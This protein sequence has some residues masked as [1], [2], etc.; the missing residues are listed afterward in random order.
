MSAMKMYTLGCRHCSLLTLFVVVTVVFCPPYFAI[1]D[2]S[3]VLNPVS[4][5]ILHH[6]SRWVHSRSKETS[7]TRLKGVNR[8]SSDVFISRG[9]Q[10]VVHIAVHKPKPE[11]TVCGLVSEHAGISIERA[12]SLASLGSIYIARLVAKDKGSGRDKRGN[13]KGKVYAGQDR[14]TGVQRQSPD[15]QTPTSTRFRTVGL[16][17]LEGDESPIPR[18]T[19]L[20]VHCDPL[21]FP[22]AGEIPWL[23]RTVTVTEDYVVVDKPWGVPTVPTLDNARESA[24]F[25][26]GAALGLAA[27]LRAVS[28]LDVCSSGLVVF[29]RTSEAAAKL[30]RTW[31]ERRVTKL[32]RLLLQPGSP[33]PVGPVVHCCRTKG[34]VGSGVPRMYASYDPQLL[35]GSKDGDHGSAWQEARLRIISCEPATGTAAKT[36]LCAGGKEGATQLDNTASRTDKGVRIDPT[37]AGAASAAEPHT[38]LVELETG[39]THQI[40]LQMA[41]LGA[42]VSGDSRYMPVTG[43]VHRGVAEDDRTDMFGPEPNRIGLQAA[44]LRFEWNGVEVGYSAGLPW[45]EEGK[46]W[47]N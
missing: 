4:H 30:N 11:S 23:E 25:Q 3:R 15:E 39:R 44:C 10:K 33:I 46:E 22:V 18:G 14:W 36:A 19:Y 32:Y 29:A 6:G 7:L 38:C 40:R 16:R 8:C 20:R 37:D 47:A 24:I 34:F 17:R 5:S 9:G 1:V 27:P 31:R 26:V 13:G 41:A 45:W 28:R 42:T 21:C 35:V 2:G 43:Q 12:S